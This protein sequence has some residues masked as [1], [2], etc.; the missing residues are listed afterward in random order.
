MEIGLR[1]LMARIVTDGETTGAAFTDWREM[2]LSITTAFGVNVLNR[3][4]QLISH[5]CHP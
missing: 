3:P 5:P 1:V 2:E 4:A